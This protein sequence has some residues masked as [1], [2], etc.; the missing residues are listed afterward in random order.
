MR[1]LIGGRSVLH[2]CVRIWRIATVSENQAALLGG[3]R[4]T[5]AQGSPQWGL[6]Q[7]K[8]AV[9]R[10]ATGCTCNPNFV[11]DNG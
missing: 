4:S 11:I 5:Y 3:E 6:V 8:F 9:T 1:Q 7:T 2:M 10:A